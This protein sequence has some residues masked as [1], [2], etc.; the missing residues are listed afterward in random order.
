[1]R[2]VTKEAMNAGEDYARDLMSQRP[3]VSQR[4]LEAELAGSCLDLVGGDEAA[5]D[6][7]FEGGCAAIKAKFEGGKSC[8]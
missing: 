4:E 6:W 5:A 7:A 2:Q 8:V 3:R 1:M